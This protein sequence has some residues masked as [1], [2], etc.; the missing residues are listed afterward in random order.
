[1]SFL[2]TCAKKDLRR[3]LADPL[4]LVLWLGIPL[5]VGGLMILMFGGQDAAPPKAHVLL[6]DEDGSVAGRLLGGLAGGGIDGFL[7]VETVT[8]QVGLERMDAGDASA[9]LVLPAGFSEAVLDQTPTAVELVKNPAQSILPGIVQTG[10]EMLVELI[11]YVQ[12]LL[13]EPVRQLLTETPEVG[14]FLPSETVA[15]VSGSIN[16][17]LA[18][19]RAWLF[20]PALTVEFVDPRTGVERSGPAPV[21]FGALFLPSMLF[22]AVLFVAQGMADDLWDEKEAGTLRRAVALPHPLSVFLAGKLATAAVIMTAVGLAS[23]VVLRSIDAVTWARIPAALGWAVFG[24]TALYCYFLALQFLAS[25]RRGASIL[26]NLVL[27]PVMMIGGAFFPFEAM[28]AWMSAVGQWTPNGQALVKELLA[29]TATLE[30]LA[31]AALAIGLPAVTA[32][33]LSTRLLG[34]RFVAEA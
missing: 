13:G 1:V 34:R 24:G 21:N 22:M 26:S 9:M 8:R 6:V 25:S 28:P 20:P 10:A 32:F 30:G 15:A 18:G 23:L 16:D 11:H 3:R 5:L 17:R 14:G 7:E 19:L 29:G 27:F 31:V 2:L 33:L 12:Q 4:A